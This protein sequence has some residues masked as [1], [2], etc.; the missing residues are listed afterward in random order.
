MRGS[1]AKFF[2]DDL[3]AA[4]GKFNPKLQGKPGW[5]FSM[6]RKDSIESLVDELNSKQ[7]PTGEMKWYRFSLPKVKVGDEGQLATGEKVTVLAKD[8]VKFRD[9]TSRMYVIDKSYAIIENNIPLC[10]TF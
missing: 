3:K 2:T 10:I 5:I 4:M 7:V 1:N 8:K 6:K 9:T